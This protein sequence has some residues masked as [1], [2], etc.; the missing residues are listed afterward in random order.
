MLVSEAFRK[1]FLVDCTLRIKLPF[2]Q[3]EEYDI[4][5]PTRD[6]ETHISPPVIITREIPFHRMISRN[7]KIFTM[8]SEI[9]IFIHKIEESP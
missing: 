5:E 2:P 6:S 9:K 1:Y 3:N 4:E 7:L 8:K